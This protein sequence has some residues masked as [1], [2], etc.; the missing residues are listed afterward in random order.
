[1]TILTTGRLTWRERRRAGHPTAPADHVAV[2]L[3]DGGTALLRPLQSGETG[4]LLE[5]F[6]QMSTASRASRYLVGL[7]RLN[8]A[9]V[10]ALAGQLQLQGPDA[11]R[12]LAR[13]GA[14]PPTGEGALEEWLG[15]YLAELSQIWIISSASYRWRVEPI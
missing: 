3:R 14:L 4:P 12:V 2:T 7:P 13:A 15:A 5:V 1:M 11:A 9:M 10:A 8:G 6:E